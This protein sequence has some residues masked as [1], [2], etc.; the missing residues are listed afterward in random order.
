M[1]EPQVSRSISSTKVKFLAVDLD[2]NQLVEME[3]DFPTE[4][5]T[6]EKIERAIKKVL[7]ENKAFAKVLSTEYPTLF[8]T[9]PLEQ[10][11]SLAKVS[12]NRLTKVTATETDT[13]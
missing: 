12:E 10:F 5:K 8:Y 1:R 11:M 9:M 6:A 3:Q 4:L 7:P 13:L 2:N